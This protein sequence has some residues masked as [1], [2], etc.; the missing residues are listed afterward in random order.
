MDTHVAIHQLGDGQIGGRTRQ[1]VRIV[2]AHAFLLNRQVDRVEQGMT[3][4]SPARAC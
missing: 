4:T 3:M 1:H 2:A